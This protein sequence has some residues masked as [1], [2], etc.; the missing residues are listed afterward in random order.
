MK[1]REMKEEMKKR[2]KR[3]VM[4][5]ISSVKMAINDNQYSKYNDSDQWLFW[6]GGEIVMTCEEEISQKENDNRNERKLV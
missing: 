2:W 4:I 5:F 6:N 1:W 3:N